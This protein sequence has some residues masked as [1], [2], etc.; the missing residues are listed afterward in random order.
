M[1]TIKHF[2]AVFLFLAAIYSCTKSDVNRN[3]DNTNNNRDS[4]YHL[5]ISGILK[6]C[7]NRDLTNGDLVIA[8]NQGYEMMHITNGRF[9]TTLTSERRF[10]SVIVWVLDMDSLTVSDTIRIHVS[11]DSINLGT[12]NACTRYVDEYVKCNIGN[13]TFVYVPMLF[14]TLRAGGF[15]T[16]GAPTTY[17]YRSSQHISNSNFYRMQFAGMS[18]GTFGVNWNSTFQM[19]RYYSFN[20]PS[21]GSITYTSYDMEGGYIKGSMNIPF[22]DNTDSMN[23]TLT[24]S[25]K[26]KRDY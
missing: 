10:D 22:I 4:T 18:T 6:T 2:L 12:L 26:V 8:T 5:N 15:D 23:Y 25:F 1:N 11:E 17:F 19:G 24:G 14:D 3:A 16:L 9:D 13:D 20:M 7:N 21:S